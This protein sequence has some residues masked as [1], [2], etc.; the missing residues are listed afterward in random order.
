MLSLILIVL[1]L[2]EALKQPEVRDR[3]ELQVLQRES[4]IKEMFPVSSK[5]ADIC[6]LVVRSFFKSI[7][8]QSLFGGISA[9]S[10]F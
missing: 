5:A 8:L 9:F 10:T 6:L 7:I 4:I 3:R 1:E 2:V